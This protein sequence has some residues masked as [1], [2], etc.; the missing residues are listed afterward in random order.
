MLFVKDDTLIYQLYVH[1]HVFNICNTFVFPDLCLRVHVSITC[2][3]WN[4]PSTSSSTHII[5]V[6]ESPLFPYPIRYGIPPLFFP[7]FSSFFPQED[8]STLYMLFVI[9]SPSL[10]SPVRYPLFTCI[11]LYPIRYGTPLNS[12]SSSLP[13]HL[14]YI[15]Y[16]YIRIL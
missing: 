2:L 9:E 13:S 16:V 12:L 5:F 1:V 6:R 10:L 7:L 15:F 11:H 8:E 14:I 4:H 3:L